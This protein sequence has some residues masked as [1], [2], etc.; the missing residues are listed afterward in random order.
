MKF[1]NYTHYIDSSIAIKGL[2][3][4]HQMPALANRHSGQMHDQTTTRRLNLV[5]WKVRR[6]ESYMQSGALSIFN[7]QSEKSRPVFASCPKRIKKANRSRTPTF[8]FISSQ[9]AAVKKE[10]PLYY[11]KN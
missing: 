10:E 4:Q 1:T 2:S 8:N 3:A 9:K 7:F 11:L 5:A 6:A